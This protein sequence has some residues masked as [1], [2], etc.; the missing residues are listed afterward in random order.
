MIMIVV[1]LMIV[2]VVVV[3]RML[4]IMVMVM[5]MCIVTVMSRVMLVIVITGA[6]GGC[7]HRMCI[8][9]SGGSSGSGHGL[10][11]QLGHGRA[12]LLLV[13]WKK[14]DMSRRG[15]FHVG[16]QDL[17]Q[18]VGAFAPLGVAR[19]LRIGDVRLDVVFHYLHHETIDRTAHGGDLLQDL[20]AALLSLERTL[21]R[22]DLT[23]DAANSR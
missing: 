20:G 10:I 3:V 6:P 8:R 15:L 4:V 1:P 2:V 5:R 14:F 22:L 12:V 19:D 11:G 7:S 21:E 23:A 18:L 13:H 16:A 17:D 9:V